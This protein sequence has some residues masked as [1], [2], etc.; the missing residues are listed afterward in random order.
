MKFVFSLCFTIFREIA[1]KFTWHSLRSN[2]PLFINKFVIT[3][4]VRSEI[5]Q[6]RVRMRKIR[7]FEVLMQK[8]LFEKKKERESDEF[9]N[10]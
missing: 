8:K 6:F 4:F 2:L 5:T 7:I 3:Q 10:K 1:N 9:V